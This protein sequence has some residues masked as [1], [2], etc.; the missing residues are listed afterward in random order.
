MKRLSILVPVVLVA[1]II[2]MML[3][4]STI[5][6]GSRQELSVM[7]SPSDA[8][9]SIDGKHVGSGLV[10]LQV[11]RSTRHLVEVTKEGYRTVQVKTGNALAGWFW[12][13]LIS[14]SVIG[15]LVDIISGAAYNIDPSP[16]LVKLDTGSGPPIVKTH[17]TSGYIYAGVIFLALVAYYVWFTAA[18]IAGFK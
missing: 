4:C 18:V 5:V 16:V 12:G 7:A 9:I 15:M 2:T 13:N 10:T 8:T 6:N 1:S 11:S 14:F 17:D 3:S